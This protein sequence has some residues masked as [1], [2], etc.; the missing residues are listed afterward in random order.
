MTFKKPLFIKGFIL[1]DKIKRLL[2]YQH[3]KVLILKKHFSGE[4]KLFLWGI[5]H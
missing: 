3:F 1:V 4:A 5:T 2:L